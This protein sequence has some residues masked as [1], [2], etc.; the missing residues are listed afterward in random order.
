MYSLSA[1]LYEHMSNLDWSLF[2]PCLFQWRPSNTSDRREPSYV[3]LIIRQLWPSASTVPRKNQRQQTPRRNQKT[4]LMTLLEFTP[5]S[6]TLWQHLTKLVNRT[7]IAMS[8]IGFNVIKNIALW[9]IYRWI[10]WDV[11]PV[12]SLVHPD[13]DLWPLTYLRDRLISLLPDVNRIDQ[14]RV[15]IDLWQTEDKTTFWLQ[16]HEI[17]AAVTMW[18]IYVASVF[19]RHRLYSLISRSRKLLNS[20]SKSSFVCI[21]VCHFILTSQ[22]QNFFM[23][24][25]YQSHLLSVGM[26]VIV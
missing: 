8:S 9:R 14:R 7:S 15:S 21:V 20:L 4:S 5:I 24:Y 2:A 17:V 3:T 12:R 18:S 10:Q 22:A 25:W 6:V 13:G 26:R 1:N 19:C 23:Q 16:R 11:Q